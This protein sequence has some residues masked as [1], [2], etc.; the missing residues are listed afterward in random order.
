MDL[1]LQ[2]LEEIWKVALLLHFH[3]FDQHVGT[4]LKVLQALDFHTISGSVYTLDR[5]D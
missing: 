2:F 4:T 1:H 3:F 5:L